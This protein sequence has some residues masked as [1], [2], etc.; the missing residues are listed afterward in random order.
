MVTQSWGL[1]E[2]NKILTVATSHVSYVSVKR[3][4]RIFHIVGIILCLWNSTVASLTHWGQVMH[5]C[6][7]KLPIIGSYNGVSP[8]RRQAITW[9][10]VGILLIGPLGTNVSEILSRIQI[11]SLKKMHLK[12]LSAKR[13]PF[14]LSL[15]VLSYWLLG[16]GSNY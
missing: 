15:N 10:K 13:R 3:D 2:I 5:I 14:C 9:T 6:V 7:S 11:F 4:C 16:Y 8:V 12:G 1:N